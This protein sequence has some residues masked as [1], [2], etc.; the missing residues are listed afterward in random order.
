MLRHGWDDHWQSTWQTSRQSLPEATGTA[1]PDSGTGPPQPGRVVRTDR[2]RCDV[3]TAAG[4]LH[5]E[6]PPALAVDPATAP[7]TGD[8]TAVSGAGGATARLLAVLPRRNALR[9]SA[10]TGSSLGQ[11]LAANVDEV[12]ITVP[13]DV[14]LRLARVE[15]LLAIAWASGARPVVVLTKA[16][17]VDDPGLE[18]AEVGAAAPGARVRA[19][20]TASGAGLAVL[21]AELTG[22]AVLVG[23]SGA[24]KS[25]LA[26][27]LLGREALAVGAV[28][29]VD[30][31]GRHTSVRR[32]LLP[33]PGGGAL[34]DTPGLRAVGLPETADG[35]RRAFAD[36]EELAAACRFGDCGH[37]GEP[38]CAVLAAIVDG[39]LPTRRL[40]GYRKL[41]REEARAAARTDQRLR[42]EQRRHRR[43]TTREH[44]RSRREREQ[45]RGDG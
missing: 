21:A 1:S 3:L 5:A 36:V 14:P 35:V 11:V 13:L 32:E 31:R 20:S 19:V 30:G 42:A 28:R 15:R 39:V 7:A 10:V 18:L 16:D 23:P 43:S 6:V 17:V 40:D 33:L 37:V 4:L 45:E 34:I 9:R 8:W 26:N 38:G 29:A 2:G 25:S 27:A 44:R 12:L 24:G 41:L 22:T